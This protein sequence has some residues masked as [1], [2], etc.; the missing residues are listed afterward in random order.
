MVRDLLSEV[1]R[2]T[3]LYLLAVSLIG[4]AM[5]STGLVPTKVATFGIELEQPN[6]SALLF[7]VALVD[8]YFLAAFVIY[9]ASDYR[10]QLAQVAAARERAAEARGWENAAEI[11]GFTAEATRVGY[12]GGRFSNQENQAIRAALEEAAHLAPAPLSLQD[13]ITGVLRTFFEFL[14]PILVGLFGVYTLL[15]QSLAL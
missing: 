10:Q 6:R 11:T 12:E 9:A 15:A 1:T 4:V 13:R 8:I 14:L 7:L 3:R 2:K 5:V